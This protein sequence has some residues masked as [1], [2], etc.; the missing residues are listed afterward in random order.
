VSLASEPSK[1]HEL[2]RFGEDFEL[3]LRA[4]QLRRSGRVLRLE[5]IPMDLL[6]LLVN[7][8]GS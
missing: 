7:Q 1:T 3:D 4:Y 6:I 5:R 8:P 2:I